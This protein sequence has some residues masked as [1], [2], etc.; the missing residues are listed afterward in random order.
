MFKQNHKRNEKKVS[1]SAFTT[2]LAVHPF[3]NSQSHTLQSSSNAFRAVTTYNR[4]R[5]TSTWPFRE[6]FDSRICPIW[7]WE[8]LAGPHNCEKSSW[9]LKFKLVR[10]QGLW[11]VAW[12]QE[13]G[14][15]GND[16]FCTLKY[17]LD[18]RREEQWWRNRAVIV[19]THGWFQ[20]RR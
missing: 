10:L 6:V 15:A 12:T 5:Q 17:S 7:Y 14:E 19:R 4:L 2:R 16:S 20:Y 13:L 8:K 18:C 3:T 1:K 9:C 11:R